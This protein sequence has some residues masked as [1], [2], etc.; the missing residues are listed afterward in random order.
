MAV[1]IESIRTTLKRYL[2]VL[3]KQDLPEL[4]SILADKKHPCYYYSNIKHEE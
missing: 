3:F 2:S 4:I 1:K